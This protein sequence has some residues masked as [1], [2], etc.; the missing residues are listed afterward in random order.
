MGQRV[1]CLA[2]A[3]RNT[4]FLP[5]TH[6]GAAYST[7][8]RG[9]IEA[10]NPRVRLPFPSDRRAAQLSRFVRHRSGGKLCRLA[11]L[12]ARTYARKAQMRF[13]KHRAPSNHRTPDL[14]LSAFLHARG[15]RIAEVENDRGRGFFIFEDTDELRRDLV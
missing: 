1:C 7:D 5:N 4:G 11:V 3:H 8:E 15:H 2:S 6:G 12:S 14:N 13:D 9:V 10:P